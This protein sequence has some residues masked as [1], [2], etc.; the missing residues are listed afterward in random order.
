VFLSENIAKRTPD[1]IRQMTR[2]LQ[3]PDRASKA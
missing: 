3:Q 2:V 1:Y